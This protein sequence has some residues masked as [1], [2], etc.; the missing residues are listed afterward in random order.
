V[1]KGEGGGPFS[2]LFA[3]A[4]WSICLF[5]SNSISSKKK[6]RGKLQRN[7]I[8]KGLKKK[9]KGRGGGAIP[10]RKR[11]KRVM[12]LPQIRVYF[13]YFIEGEEETG[14]ERVNVLC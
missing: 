3:L 2:V 11:K 7:L 12:G 14:E 8:T 10:G 9:E 4:F 1:G 5:L 13:Y 6:G